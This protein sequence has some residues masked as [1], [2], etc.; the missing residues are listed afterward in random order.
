VM[1]VCDRCIG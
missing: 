1:S